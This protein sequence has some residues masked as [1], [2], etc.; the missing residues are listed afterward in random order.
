M[1][2][3]LQDMYVFEKIDKMHTYL[4][5]LNIC[6]E[7]KQVLNKIAKKNLKFTL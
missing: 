3:N 5:K 4:Q 6:K 7:R 2:K 1:C